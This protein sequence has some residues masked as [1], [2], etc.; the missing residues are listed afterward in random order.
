VL[1]VA[2]PAQATSSSAT[3]ALTAGVYGA[4]LLLCH[5][6]SE[7]S[8]SIRGVQMPVCARCTALYLAGALG[9]LAAWGARPRGAGRR[10]VHLALALLPMG[11]SVGLEWSGLMAGGN[12]LRAASALPAGGVAGWV[13][14][15]LLRSD[16]GRMRYDREV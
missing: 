7:R 3:F 16:P 5:Q 10:G 2:V 15:Q 12:V 8:F 4:G 1:I 13:V 14:V 11:I 6:R 9:A